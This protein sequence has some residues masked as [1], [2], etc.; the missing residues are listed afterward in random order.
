MTPEQ[1][2][3]LDAWIAEHLTKCAMVEKI[4]PR[5]YKARY[6]LDKIPGGVGCSGFK[7]VEDAWNYLTNQIPHPSTDKSEA[8]WVLEKCHEKVGFGIITQSTATGWSIRFAINGQNDV[9]GDT[10]PIAICLFAKKL[11]SK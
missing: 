8:F 2:R 1:M 4:S 7:S 9:H 10:L 5:R 11:F 3:E 6:H